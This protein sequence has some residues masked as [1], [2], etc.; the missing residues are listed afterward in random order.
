MYNY[1]CLLKFLTNSTFFPFQNVFDGEIPKFK[2]G[3]LAEMF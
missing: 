3:T 1:L 2:S